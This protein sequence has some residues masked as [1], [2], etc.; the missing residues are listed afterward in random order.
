MEH[1]HVLWFISTCEIFKNKPVWNWGKRKTKYKTIFNAWRFNASRIQMH[2]TQNKFPIFHIFIYIF[3]N[4][5]L[6]ANEEQLFTLF[7]VKTINVSMFYPKDNATTWCSCFSLFYFTLFSSFL[8][9]TA[10][11]NKKN[12]WMK[13]GAQD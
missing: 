13:L 6:I 4:K 12:M 10:K 11:E 8:I 9:Q 2:F 3:L 7:I 1:L 5:N